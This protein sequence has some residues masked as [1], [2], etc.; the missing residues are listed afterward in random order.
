MEVDVKS[1]NDLCKII[2]CEHKTAPY[3]DASPFLVVRTSNVRNGRISFKDIKYT[4]EA[5]YHEWTQRA[6]PES[7]DILF[8]REAPAGESC[9][10]PKELK[11][12]MG[13]RMVLIRPQKNK[14]DSHYLSLYLA[15]DKCK[16]DIHRLTIGTTVSRI[17]IA[18]IKKIN[19]AYPSLP[20]QKKIAK[21]LSTW[22]KAIET[23]EQLIENSKLQKKALMQIVFCSKKR[24]QNGWK[25]IRLG[26]LTSIFDGTHSTPKYVEKG[27]PFYSVEHVTSDNFESTKYI[28]QEVFEKENKR[29]KLETG[30]ILMTRI[31]DIGTVKYLDWEVNASFYVSLALIKANDNY[32]SQFLSYYIQS[33]DFQRELWKRT[34]HVAFPKK[35]NLGEI[36]NCEVSMP[37]IDEQ[38]RIV[39]LLSVADQTISHLE[40]KLAILKQEKKA[41][42]QQLLTGKRRVVVHEPVVEAESA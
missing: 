42:M 19:V 4:T 22:D 31:G 38:E 35:I 3:V 7:G 25:N 40:S 36:G 41:L 21:I 23:V 18:D 8:T 12:C 15:T 26:E 11:L 39:E 24:S 5:G 9:L 6:V 16:F 29:V 1:I 10:V 32:S 34:I 14:V 13:Q 27:V 17:N 37:D 28:S 2:D 20:E 33:D 30:D